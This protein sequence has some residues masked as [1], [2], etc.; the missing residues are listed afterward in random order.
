MEE[1]EGSE[2]PIHFTGI[3]IMSILMNILILEKGH[4]YL[5]EYL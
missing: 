2:W 1:L 5:K 4:D 3:R